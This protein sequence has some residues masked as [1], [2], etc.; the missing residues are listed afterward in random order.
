MLLVL[1][2]AQRQ[3]QA[4]WDFVLT[5]SRARVTQSSQAQVALLPKTES[6]IVGVIPWQQLS[7]HQ[8]HVPSNMK[9]L[10]VA[11]NA[12]APSVLESGSNQPSKSQTLMQGLLEEQTL[13][14]LSSLHW[15]AKPVDFAGQLGGSA[16]Q[17]PRSANPAAS[18]SRDPSTAASADTTNTLWVACCD[19]LWLR[20][21]LQT[22]ESAG[23]TPQRLVPELEPVGGL[24]AKWYGLRLGGA[25]HVVLCTNQ[26]VAGFNKETWLAMTA[27]DRTPALSA[28]GASPL[29][30]R[31]A[32]IYATP[33]SIAEA[34]EVLGV[35]PELQTKAQRLVLASFSEWD[36]AQ[37]EWAQGASRRWR[38]SMQ[39]A[40]QVFW[41]AREYQLAKWGLL[42][43]LTLQLVALN[44]SSWQQSQSLQA[45]TLAMK[46]ILLSTF[47]QVQV[48]VDPALQMQRELE[49][50]RQ[51]KAVA[52]PGDFERLLEVLGQLQSTPPG[53]NPSTGTG[54][55][56]YDQISTLRYSA[57]ELHV[58]FANDAPMPSTPNLS[59]Q[60]LSLG[61]QLRSSAPASHEWVLSWRPSP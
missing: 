20:Q 14:D 40:W 50:L 8:V 22:L 38:K 2:P 13:Q 44:A 26:S 9:R 56:A 30:P 36:F 39:K 1:L 3:A 43:L 5:D 32:Q 10:L 17:E 11:R 4:E 51:R 16:A 41:H 12:S 55:L 42:G 34:S 24:G 60:A 59:P 19:K 27:G 58:V 54:M 15:I 33:E 25:L 18:P 49:R 48:V 37:G 52:S 28:V 61:Y 6:D 29:D 23:L 35:T 46:G 7:W 47:P 31:G 45:Q 21:T 53:S 57:Q